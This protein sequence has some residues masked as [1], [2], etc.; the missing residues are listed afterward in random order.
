[1]V[2]VVKLRIEHI[3]YIRNVSSNFILDCSKTKSTVQV[4]YFT[5]FNNNDNNNYMFI[6]ILKSKNKNSSID[7]NK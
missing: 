5:S 7:Y 3:M 2:V 1:M 4:Q 6:C